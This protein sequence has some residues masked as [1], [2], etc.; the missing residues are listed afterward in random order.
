MRWSAN[1]T[2]IVRTLK[3]S[4]ILCDHSSLYS[5]IINILI[6]WK[7]TLKKLLYEY[8]SHWWLRL[9]KIHVLKF[10]L[11]D[12]LYKYDFLGTWSETVRV[13][14]RTVVQT[15]KTLK[16][17]IV[18]AWGTIALFLNSV[19][20]YLSFR[21]AQAFV[22]NWKSK[23]PRLPKRQPERKYLYESCYFL[24]S[25]F[26]SLMRIRKKFFFLGSCFFRLE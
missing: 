17:I 1:V 18:G 9:K 21:N 15:V 16:R 12:I 5:N 26:Y 14:K 4:S 19:H 23:N 22:W 13:L 8:S 11:L 2:D 20:T 7:I 24:S 3:N 25:I 6:F 10:I